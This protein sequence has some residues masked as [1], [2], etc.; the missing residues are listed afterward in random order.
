MKICSMK[1]CSTVLYTILLQAC[2]PNL[3]WKCLPWKVLEAKEIRILNLQSPYSAVLCEKMFFMTFYP[4]I[5]KIKWENSGNNNF[6]NR[7]AKLNGQVHAVSVRRTKSAFWIPNGDLHHPQ[8][9]HHGEPF[10]FQQRK[11]TLLEDSPLWPRT[12]W[13]SCS[14]LHLLQA[15]EFSCWWRYNHHP[16]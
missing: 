15:R 5:R 6:L 4:N 12:W 14:A 9:Q 1:I 10:H 2:V 7:S 3:S 13:A 11:P 8:C 16:Q